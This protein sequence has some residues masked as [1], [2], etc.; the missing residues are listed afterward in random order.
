MIE[1]L[2]SFILGA[3]FAI[4]ILYFKYHSFKKV[5]DELLIDRERKADALKAKTEL[6]LK[7]K[8]L[9]QLKEFESLKLKAKMLID[10]EEAHLAQRSEKL[11]IRSNRLDEKSKEIE[12]EKT[13]LEMERK[14]LDTRAL[15]LEQEK[16]KILIELEKISSLTSVEAKKE[17]LLKVKRE[18]LEESARLIETLTKEAEG[19]AER[20][21][22]RLIS[23]AIRR[24]AVPCVSQLATAS[25]PI[26]TEEMKGRVIGRE[27]R[28]I[29]ALEKET[30]VTFSIDDQASCAVLS[31]FDP[32]RLHIAKRALIELIR[33]GRI[34]PARIE[35]TVQEIKKSIKDEIERSGEM[36]AL[37]TNQIDL[38][39]P[40]ITLLGQM[41]FFYS[42]GQNLLDHS[43]EVS[44]LAGLMAA[45]LDL[46][47]ALAKR[48]GLL[49]DIGKVLT[50][51]TEGSHALSGHS[52]LLAHGEKEVVANGVGAHHEEMAPLTL[53]A[54]LVAS[55]DALSAGRPGARVGALDEYIKR[56]KDLEKIASDFTAVEKVHVLQ[57]GRE[58]R[59]FVHPGMVTDGEMTHL[60]RDIGKRIR[61]ELS[62]VGSLK[63]TLLRESRLVEFING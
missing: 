20:E 48:I 1:I 49:H 26:P 10:R 28:N 15:A 53:E 21:A 46:D 29:Y 38:A 17:L 37:K 13:T 45:E 18:T 55:A 3:T 57:S 31:G 54:S 14:A 19:K 63:I 16:Q 52:F 39:P 7:T 43:L 9:E 33:D 42:F 6:E 32:L 27:G 4:A 5:A 11:E 8:S 56:L 12:S 25:V 58:I 51:E 36:A 47:V 50:Y 61:S 44:H 35:E 2:L 62:H 60:A 24:L 23:I 30:G 34:H 40:V 59:V 41:K 22:K